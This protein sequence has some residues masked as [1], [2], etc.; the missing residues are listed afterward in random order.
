[1]MTTHRPRGRWCSLLLPGLLLLVLPSLSFAQALDWYTVE[2]LVFA[3]RD[4]AG[5][6]EEV[7]SNNPGTP[8]VS[9]ALEPG[10]DGSRFEWLPESSLELAAVARQLNRSGRYRT[11]MLSGWRQP[12]YGPRRAVPVHLR[13]DPSVVLIQAAE[14]GVTPP[15]SVPASDSGA[16]DGIVRVHRSRY[17]HVLVDL[18][19]TRPAEPGAGAADTLADVP[20]PVLV[21]MTQTRRMRSR[22]LYYYDHPLFGVLVKIIPYG[23][24]QAAEPTEDPATA[25]E[26]DHEAAAPASD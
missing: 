13:S 1:M 3:E 12:G 6:D 5:L 20:K 8:D 16:V 4:S 26:D 15:A 19:Y 2:I 18:L 14:P 25:P 10:S 7:W 22:E 23:A 9:A 21:R 11:L 24:Q 17:L